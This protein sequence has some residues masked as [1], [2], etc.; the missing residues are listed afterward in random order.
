MSQKRYFELF[1]SKQGGVPVQ[2]LYMVDIKK[3]QFHAMVLVNMIAT[4]LKFQNK[5]LIAI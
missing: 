3:G 4:V 1:W 2:I 5:D